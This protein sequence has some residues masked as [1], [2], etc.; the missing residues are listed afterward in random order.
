MDLLPP[1]VMNAADG[2]IDYFD[3][4]NG[5]QLVIP[6]YSGAIANELIIIN[7][8]STFTQKQVI[9]GVSDF[10]M[11]FNVSDNFPPACL[12]DGIYDI[13]YTIM[14]E[15]MNTVTSPSFSLTVSTNG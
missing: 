3:L 5:V 12:Y 13:T 14:D 2:V 10:P 9:T 6:T 8:G 4:K 15:S 11:V 7:W 1:I